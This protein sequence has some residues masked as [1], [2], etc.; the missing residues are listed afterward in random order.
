[1]ARMQMRDGAKLHYIDVGRGEP[2]VLL[3]GFAMQGALWLPFALRHAHRYRFILPDLRGFGRSHGLALATPVLLDQHANDLADLV[4]G[5]GLHDF[6]LGGL[7][8]GACTA[9]QYHRR[10]GFE[11]VRAYL[12]IDQAPRVLNAAD[13]QCG[14]MGDE[15]DQRLS[16]W[17]AVMEQLEPWRG[18]SFR[19]IPVRLRQ[20]FW[21]VLSDFYGSAFHRRGWKQ[22]TRLARY[23]RFVQAVAPTRHWTIYLDCMRSYLHDNY[24]WRESLKSLDTPMTAMVGMQ[25]AMY[26]AEGQLHIQDLV[27]HARIERFEQC[28]HAI[29]FD[30]PIRFQRGLGRFLRE[31]ADAGLARPRPTVG[32][33]RAA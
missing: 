14:L 31:T 27:P 26:P 20:R 8:M 32:L 13:W 28:G 16:E 29:P 10:Y 17:A 12:H 3:H 1:M 22:T 11:G 2:V 5:L 9:L 18:R 30:A 4:R 33:S 21:H 24:D 25:S 23:E 7:S 15:Q 19:A 6:R